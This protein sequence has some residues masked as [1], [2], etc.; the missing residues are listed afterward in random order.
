MQQRKLQNLATLAAYIKANKIEY[1]NRPNPIQA[2]LIDAFLDP[3]YRVLVCT[4]GNRGGKTT[5]LTILAFA[6]M[7]GK[8]PWNNQE[9]VF[10][11]KSPRKVRLVGQDWESHIKT[12]LEPKLT[13]WWPKNRA[14]EVKKNNIGVRAFWKDLQTGSTLQILSN[15][16]E[17]DVGEGWDG[18]LIGY[19]EP[20]K[21]SMR[22][23]CARGLVDRGGKEI[24]SMT[25]L[26]EAWVSRE[27]MKAVDEDGNPDRTIFTISG[28]TYDNL[29]Y[30]LTKEN[31]EQYRKTLNPDEE[32]AR[33][34]GIPSYMSSLIWPIDRKLHVRERFRVPMHWIVDWAIDFHPAKP[35][36]CMAV[37]TDERN[38]KYVIDEIWEHGTPEYIADS[39][40]R[41]IIDGKYRIANII[42]DPLSRGDGN[43]EDTV[44][45]RMQKVFMSYGF[46][47]RVGSKEKENGIT[48]IKDFLRAQ[49]GIPGL[50]FFHDCKKTIQQCEDWIYDPETLKPSK[51]DDD[52][53]ENL[54]R[55]GLLNTQ[56]WEQEE[57]EP[58]R[59]RQSRNAVT[60]Y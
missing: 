19:D 38:F 30:G 56:W 58:R 57:Y 25:L 39:I 3:R 20:P 22:I 46:V 1:F 52:M 42:I 50:Y 14:V 24:F 10:S 43:N 5:I 16:S 55:I 31:I 53:P 7:F 37:A 11:H 12:V 32:Q 49:N 36:A 41:K 4:M 2:A 45:E 33:I 35:W 8:L 26:K 59:E 51:K 60:G 40:V 47:M 27:V 21:R 28:S 17:S 9:L 18:D 44:Y 23:A 29:G 13:E 34:W 54:Y 48:I 15:Q 6:T